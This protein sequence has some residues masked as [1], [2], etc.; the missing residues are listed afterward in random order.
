MGL[1][2][3]LSHLGFLLLSHDH[4]ISAHKI[5][6]NGSNVDVF[7]LAL[8]TY[9]HHIPVHSVPFDRHPFQFLIALRSIVF[10]LRNSSSTTVDI[11]INIFIDAQRKPVT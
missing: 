11:I 10:P 1:A 7:A 8:L 5:T 3:Q 4:H 2:H 9:N 6:V